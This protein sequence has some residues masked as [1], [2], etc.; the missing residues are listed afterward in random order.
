MEHSDIVVIYRKVL[1][2]ELSRFPNNSWTDMSGNKIGS[3]IGECVRYLLEEVL[4]WS[5]EE[6]KENICSQTF[7]QNKLG[8]VMCLYD[9]SPFELLN[10]GYPNRFK[11][12]ELNRSQKNTWDI[13]TCKKAT[14][15]M[16]EEK[17]CWSKED[18][19][20][21][22]NNKTFEDNHLR[23]VMKFCKGS[24]YYML[25]L[26]YP[27]E[28]QPW[29]L[30]CSP[31]STWGDKDMI[32]KAINWLITDRLGWTVEFAEN[33]LTAKIINENG[34]SSILRHTTVKKIK[35]II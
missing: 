34:F 28:Y 24:P 35:E 13:E 3:N 18:V 25:N 29:E 7:K 4:V 17:L 27:N 11:P 23:G 10:L 22:L 16:I 15:W 8:G 9:N 21:N 33:N 19:K 5:K 2:G 30:K 26:T 14:R 20:S 12:W 32:E 1:S 31:M 6:I